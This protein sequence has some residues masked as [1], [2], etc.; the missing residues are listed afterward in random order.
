MSRFGINTVCITLLLVIHLKFTSRST[1]WY[2]IGTR[3]AC[4]C[5][6]IR[7]PGSCI[8]RSRRHFFVKEYRL[9][10]GGI[11]EDIASMIIFAVLIKCF[12]I[13]YKD[14]LLV[15]T[16]INSRIKGIVETL[17]FLRWCKLCECGNMLIVSRSSNIKIVSPEL[18]CD[19]ICRNV[20]LLG[21]T[22][23]VEFIKVRTKSAFENQT[24]R[25][26]FICVLHSN[27]NIL[28]Q[29]NICTLK[30]YKIGNHRY[31]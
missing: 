10:I 26:N 15:Y 6:K 24:N 9:F 28:C 29:F 2:N 18:S 30:C 12:I 21:N 23:D 22:S 27:I 4:K 31:Q 8:Y 3:F 5:F 16:L 25:R 17:V 14:I 1:F 13:F 20:L 7:F 11:F 19:T